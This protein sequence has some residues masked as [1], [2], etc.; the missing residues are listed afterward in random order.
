MEDV[1]TPPREWLGTPTSTLDAHATGF[2]LD[3]HHLWLPCHFGELV[4][5]C[6]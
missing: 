5:W 3:P 1:A 4:C 2:L 6:V